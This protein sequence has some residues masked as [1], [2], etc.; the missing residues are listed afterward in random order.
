MRRKLF[1]YGVDAPIVVSS[2]ALMGPVIMGLGII[3]WRLLHS[4]APF[5]GHGLLIYTLLG[6]L[7]CILATALLLWSSGVG[8]QR[9]IRHLFDSLDW[10][11]DERVLD[12]GC[13]RGA[14]L[15]QAA[16]R[17]PRGNAIGL[18]LWRKTD[19]SGNSRTRT[20]ETLQRRAVTGRTQLVT[21][22]MT[23][24]PFADAQFDRI[25]ACL[26]FYN[27]TSMD[28]RQTALKEMLRVLKPEGAFY[29][30]ECSDTQELR[31]YLE[32]AG[33]AHVHTSKRDFRM[34]PPVKTITGIKP[35]S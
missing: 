34:Y 22:P 13:G 19:Q 23:A 30:V 18:D 27:L 29:L 7:G 17:L 15:V 32:H 11:G 5:L 9:V 26:S 20:L 21:A 28:E 3:V 12:L 1:P 16:H 10:R 8:K 35:G 33:A 4:H 24:L 31:D 14:L 2:L 25:F 6:G